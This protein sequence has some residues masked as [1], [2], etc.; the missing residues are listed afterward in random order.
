MKLYPQTKIEIGRPTLLLLAGGGQ[1]HFGKMNRLTRYLINLPCNIISYEL[2][3]HGSSN[4]SEVI[5]ADQFLKLFRN[6]IKE[7]Y[8]N[9]PNLIMMGFSLGG[10]LILKTIEEKLIPLNSAIVFGTGVAINAEEEYRIQSFT[11]PEFFDSMGWTLPM[12]KFHGKGWEILLPSLAKILKQDSPIWS[13]PSKL[14]GVPLHFILGDGDQ[15]F[16]FKENFTLLKYPEISTHVVE[17]CHHFE[18]YLKAWPRVE[19]ALDKIIPS[20]IPH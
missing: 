1:R 19:S 10:L 14:Q 5:D 3:G 9:Y 12:K 4:F 20:M 13:N 11:T 8:K 6:D 18:Y 17:N 16:S 2:P 7:I 15:A